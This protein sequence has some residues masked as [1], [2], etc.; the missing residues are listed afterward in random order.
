MAT[1]VGQMIALD[2]AG[3]Y[4]IELLPLTLAQ[5][6]REP[7]YGRIT[8]H[9]RQVRCLH[10]TIRRTNAP[11]VHI[12]TCSG[13]SFYRSV[14]DMM[15]GRRLG[16]RVILHI[17]GAK[18]DKFYA[19]EPLWRRRL[20][21]RSLA[22]ADRIVALS[23]RWRDKLQHMSPNARVDIVENAVE[24][25]SG[26]PK[27]RQDGTCCFLLLARMDEWKGIDDLLDACTDL[28]RQGVAV[29]VVLA[30]PSG[31]SGN[32][33]VLYEKIRTRN[34]VGMVRYVGPVH[35]EAKSNLLA[36][37]DAYVQPS[38]HE[39]MPIA[40]LEALAYGLPVVATHVGAVPEVVNDGRHGLLV[41]PR[42][43]DLLARAMR[44]LATEDQNR[45]DMSRATRALA[46]QRFG[47]AR[48]QRDLTSLYD[49]LTQKAITVKTARR[50]DC[51]GLG[52][53]T[54]D[55]SAAAAPATDSN[56]SE[57]LAV[58]MCSARGATFR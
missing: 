5:S 16:C 28:R 40:L 30:G 41:P 14:V 49:S 51:R 54:A 1:V 7:L 25:P 19:H 22:R 15:I 31:T 29:E 8:R 36:A 21:A 12:H 42:R 2:F 13:F 4:S 24:I 58:L 34:L 48:F 35:G 55:R 44:R 39:G 10:T 52:D 3:R 47:L 20:V 11:I 33:T 53:Y 26:T 45:R 46:V 57:P 37:A 27:R 38:H 43:P 18:F 6:P 23:S 50:I 9:I 32:A 56:A 17:H